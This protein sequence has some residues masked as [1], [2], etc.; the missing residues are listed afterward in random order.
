[1][2]VDRWAFLCLRVEE[3]KAGRGVLGYR[4]GEGLEERRRE[5]REEERDFGG[6]GLKWVTRLEEREQTA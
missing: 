5:A 3:E 1:M 6:E 2:W 4:E